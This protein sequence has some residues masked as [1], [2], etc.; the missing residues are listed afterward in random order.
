MNKTEAELVQKSI[1]SE[2]SDQRWEC[3]LEESDTGWSVLVVS[4]DARD[5]LLVEPEL[6]EC[7]GRAIADFDALMAVCNVPIPQS[8]LHLED[9]LGVLVH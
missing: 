6:L 3:L 8:L 9:R 4:Q 5:E 7:V 2:V 1:E